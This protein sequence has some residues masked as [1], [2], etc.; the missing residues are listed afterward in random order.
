MLGKSAF[1]EG[2]PQY[3]GIYN[4]EVGDPYVRNTVEESDCLLML[5]AFM[6]DINLG[7]FTAH[8]DPAHTVCATSEHILIKHHEYTDVLFE[9]FHHRIGGKPGSA[10]P[11]SLSDYADETTCC[12]FNRQGFY[13]WP[14]P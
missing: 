5:G 8:L 6:T 12:A 9:D 7:L 2:H 10:P 13:E 11:R 14:A 3:I 4:G 1:P